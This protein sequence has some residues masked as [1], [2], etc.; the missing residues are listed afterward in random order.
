M[1]KLAILL[2]ALSFSQFASAVTLQELAGSYKITHPDLPVVY[3]VKISSKGNVA[4]TESSPY[5]KLECTGKGK[6]SKDILSSSV[7]CADG[8]EF[9]QKIN[10]NGVKN[11]KRF[12][13]TVFSS[14]YGQEVEMNFER[15]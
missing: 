9:A 8:Q 3:I 1:K 14:L 5:G 7:K 2:I 6:L 4:L 15:L 11:L 13:A 12:T 10:L